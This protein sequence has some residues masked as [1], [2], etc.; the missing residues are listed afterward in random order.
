M[1]DLK[2]DNFA[3]TGGG[4]Q[5]L[6]V[7]AGQIPFVM[8]DPALSGSTAILYPSTPGGYFATSPVQPLIMTSTDGTTNSVLCYGQALDIGSIAFNS[9][10]GVSSTDHIAVVVGNGF[11]GPAGS[12]TS[13]PIAGQTPAIPLSPVLAVIKYQPG[14]LIR[15][16][17]H[18]S[19]D[20]IL[21]LSVDSD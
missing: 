8:A 19:D 2:A 20:W 16:S 5:V 18:A 12:A 15:Q 10:S 4:S 7:A 17:A 3:T 6:I 11:S 9:S 13:C 14:V 21:A 1:F